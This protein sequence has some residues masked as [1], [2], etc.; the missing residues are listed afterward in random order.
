MVLRIIKGPN[1]NYL[2]M[3]QTPIILLLVKS[4]K[5]LLED[6]IFGLFSLM[7]V[8]TKFGTKLLGVILKIVLS[9]Q[10]Q[11]MKDIF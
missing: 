1:N 7:K 6:M 5:I 11:T 2:S 4:Q 3:D 8:E 9:S 10:I